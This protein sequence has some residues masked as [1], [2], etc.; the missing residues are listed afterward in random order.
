MIYNLCYFINIS[1]A[2]KIQIKAENGKR[3]AENF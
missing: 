1:N 3:K 2:A